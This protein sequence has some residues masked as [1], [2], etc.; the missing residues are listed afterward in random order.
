[1]KRIPYKHI[2]PYMIF[3]AAFAGCSGGGGGGGADDFGGESEG[4]FMGGVYTGTLYLAQDTCGVAPDSLITT[5]T[6]NQDGDRIV[7]DIPSGDTFTGAPTAINA[8]RVV[9]VEQSSGCSNGS[10][11]TAILFDN[12][13]DEAADVTFGISS[14]CGVFTCS[15]GLVG[16]LTRN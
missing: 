10:I 2:I 1:M 7:A 3:L 6:V 13:T 16:R 5:I 9:K 14:T 4:Q 8:F 15:G 12:V 11:T